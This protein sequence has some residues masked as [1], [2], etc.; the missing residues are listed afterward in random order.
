[1]RDPSP[2]AQSTRP[3]TRPAPRNRC[4]H[5]KRS[6][7]S[8]DVLPQPTR[9]LMRP[10]PRPE[11]LSRGCLRRLVRA[12]SAN[13]P[14]T[15]P[16]QPAGAS[17]KRRLSRSRQ[18][19]RPDAGLPFGRFVADLAPSFGR[20]VRCAHCRCSKNVIQAPGCY[21]FAGGRPNRGRIDGDGCSPGG[22]SAWA[23]WQRAT[24]IGTDPRP[25]HRGRCHRAE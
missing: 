19:A 13:P 15:R 18:Q 9:T 7:A 21:L 10:A 24:A 3:G 1:M 4:A 11:E 6:A 23:A 20:V 22:S 14:R 25:G 8:R 16:G 2:S 12:P 5:R 17:S